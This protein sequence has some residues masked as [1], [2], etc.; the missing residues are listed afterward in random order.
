MGTLKLN[1]LSV[2]WH[3]TGRPQKI[4]GEMP[5]PKAKSTEEAVAEFLRTNAAEIGLHVAPESLRVVHKTETPVRT[6]LRYQQVIGE[7]P[8]HGSEVIVHTDHQSTVKQLDMGQVTDV[9]IAG[10][11]NKKAISLEEAY[12]V[13]IKSLGEVSLRKTK[14]Q[15]ENVYFPTD[16]GLRIAYQVLIPTQNPMHDWRIFV[17]A[18]SGAI[19][20]KTDLIKEMPDGSGLVFDPNPVVIANDNTLRQPTA[21]IA[22]GCGYAGSTLATIDAQR[23]TRT[24]KDLTFSAGV[25]SLDGPYAKIVNITAP[26]STIPTE[27]TATNFTYS[28][29]D[30]R[31]GAVNLYYHIDTIQRYIQSLGITTANNRQT[32]ADPVVTAAGFSAY[33]SP[34]DKSLHMGISRPCHPDKAQEGDAIVH[35][36]GHAIQDNQVPGWGGTNPTTGRNETGAMGEGFGDTLACVFFASFGNQFQRETFEDW[37]YVENGTAGLRRV[38]GTKLYPTDWVGEVHSDGEIWSAA[39]W[40]IYRAIGGDSM[41]LSDRQAARDAL[42]KSV[43]LSHPLLA[44]TA[45]MPDGAEA[46]MT[47]NAELDDFRGRHLMQMLNSFHNRGILRCDPAADLF[48]R[49]DPADPGTEP[50]AGSVFWESPDLWVR[51]ADDNGT[52]HEEPKSGQDN[53]FYGRVTNRGTAAARAFVVTFNVKPWA[54]VEFLYPADFI[55]FI[56]AAPGFNVAPGAFTI[57]KAKW[58]AAMVPGVGT[59]ACLLGQVYMPTDV[60]SSGVHVWDSN[61]LA[62]KNMTVIMADA[63]DTVTAHFQIG[64]LHQR[65]PNVYNVELIRPPQVRV[66][67]L[68]ANAFETRKLFNSISEWRPSR[69]A[70]VSPTATLKFKEHTRMELSAKGLSLPPVFLD[71]A[72]GSSVHQ[73]AATPQ[74]RSRMPFETKAHLV[75]SAHGQVEIEFNHDKVSGFPVLLQP[76]AALKCA[77]KI[78]VPKEAKAGENIKLQLLQRHADGKIAGGITIVV[79]VRHKK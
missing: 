52:T 19:L 79:N 11:P 24:L 13:A 8:V 21:T 39:L 50:F 31:L 33:Y 12:N 46:V 62:Q 36:Y 18:Q 32:E 26:A 37:P 1:Q 51:N 38:D 58:P 16:E 61:N 71:F 55:P 17:D 15:V 59:H 77:L 35:E 68:A 43:I 34:V 70:V 64:S 76:G 72:P 27:A 60:A 48:M 6:I 40:N 65:I 29:S 4:R 56:S 74:G 69:T 47:T 41:V 73:G 57:V 22:G 63:G 10:D 20:E 45:S 25:Y 42:L 49:D 7:I 53:Y 28:S 67:L 2:D 23:V 44:T 78:A 3:P 14:P 66:S 54:G 5:L 75:E 30:E 9:R